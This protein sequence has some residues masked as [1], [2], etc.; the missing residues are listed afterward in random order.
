MLRS[1][2]FGKSRIS[3]T[4]PMAFALGMGV[5]ALFT[6]VLPPASEASAQ[7]GTIH[8]GAAA[9]QIVEADEP[10]TGGLI[11]AA[12][13]R[14][15]MLMELRT[16]GQRMQRIEVLLQSG[17]RVEVTEMPPIRLPAAGN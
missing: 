12:Q 6:G 1:T 15:Q 10:S 4:T 9:M 8:G 13:Q 14:K 5:M 16:L 2:L 11:S 17:L 7:A 3:L